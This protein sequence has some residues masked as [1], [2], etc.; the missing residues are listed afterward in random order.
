MDMWREEKGPIQMRR[1]KDWKLFYSWGKAAQ[2]EVLTFL[3]VGGGRV[4]TGREF[5]RRQLTCSCL[6]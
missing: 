4:G 6:E 1:K 2:G 5:G 3:E